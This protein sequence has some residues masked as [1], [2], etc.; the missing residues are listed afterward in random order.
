[1][2]TT[3]SDGELVLT[4]R[5]R[6]AGIAP[7]DLSRLFERFFRGRGSKP[8]VSGTGMGLAIA[9]GLLAA[10]GGRIWAENCDDGGA[11]FTIAVPVESKRAVAAS[12]PS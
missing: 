2:Q 9:R 4:V 8:N 10:Q 1:V 12:V 5:D 7:A 6:G 11:R 3:I